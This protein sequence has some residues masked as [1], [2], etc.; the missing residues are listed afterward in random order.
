[1]GCGRTD[2]GVHASQFFAHLDLDQKPEVPWLFK[3]NKILPDGISVHEVIPVKP[4]AHAQH[5]A[6]SRTYDYYWHFYKNPFLNDRSTLYLPQKLDKKKLVSA[7]RLFPQYQDYRSFCKQPDLYK[8]TICEISVAKLYQSPDGKA[9]RLTLSS[10]R[11]LRGMMRLIAERLM[12]LGRGEIGLEEFEG[13]LQNQTPLKHRTPAYPQGL[14]LSKVV[15]PYLDLPSKETE[16]FG[17]ELLET[18]SKGHRK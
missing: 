17:W 16:L 2:A 12:E 3:L 11:F 5:D 4:D 1:M 10:N 13:Y 6:I 15:Y 9:M 18:N 14:F 8:N 7:T